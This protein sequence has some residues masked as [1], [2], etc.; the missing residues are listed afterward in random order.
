MPKI[1]L[2]F[3]FGGIFLY[4]PPSEP[5]PSLPQKMYSIGFYYLNLLHREVKGILLYRGF[6]RPILPTKHQ[7]RSGQRGMF[8]MQNWSR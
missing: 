7:E 6:S 4:L 8:S 3:G 5:P 1:F 2:V